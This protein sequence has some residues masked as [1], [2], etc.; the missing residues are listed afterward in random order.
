MSTDSVWMNLL[1]ASGGQN[2]VPF[3]E[4]DSWL[5]GAGSS[6]KGL[7]TLAERAASSI[8]VFHCLILDLL[9]DTYKIHGYS[10]ALTT[11]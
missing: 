6:E 4:G 8:I 1:G 3:T 5:L 11:T 7:E 9:A 2:G 10:I